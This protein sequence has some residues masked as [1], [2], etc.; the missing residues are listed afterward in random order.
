MGRRDVRHVPAL[1]RRKPLGAPAP[2]QGQDAQHP[3]GH[4]LARPEP[5]GLQA[6]QQGNRQPLHQSVQAQRRRYLPNLRCLERHSQRARQR[7]GDQGMRRL[8]R[9][10]DQLHDQP[11]AHARQLSGI[12][13]AAQGPRCRFHRHQGHGGHA[14]P[15]PHR[16]HGQ[17]PERALPSPT[18]RARLWPSATATRRWR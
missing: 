13:P 8:V 6:L 4:A 11:G 7:R 5:C 18:R 14:H 16:A 2:D 10:R 12:R 3:P 9:R 17:G 15:L 1:P